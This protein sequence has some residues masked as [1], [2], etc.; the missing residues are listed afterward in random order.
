MYRVLPARTTLTIDS[1]HVHVCLFVRRLRRLPL[2][3]EVW[4][5]RMLGGLSPAS[6]S[7][8]PSLGFLRAASSGSRNVCLVRL[9]LLIILRR[10]G[11]AGLTCI[12]QWNMLVYRGFNGSDDFPEADIDTLGT[13]QASLREGSEAFVNTG[14]KVFL[15]SLV[16]PTADADLPVWREVNRGSDKPVVRI[17]ILHVQDRPIK[18]SWGQESTKEGKVNSRLV[19]RLLVCRTGVCGDTWGV[20]QAHVV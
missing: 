16:P 5:E 20:A 6:G 19:R 14:A 4:C 7:F 10:V 2:I 15:R 9:V 3:V 13:L 17:E 11:L 12:V 8:G 1:V 18:Q